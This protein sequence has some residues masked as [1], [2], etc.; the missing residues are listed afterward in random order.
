MIP[1]INK[2]GILIG[3]GGHNRVRGVGKNPKINKR[4]GMFIWDLRVHKIT[5]FLFEFLFVLT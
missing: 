2:R 3:S 5:Y 1:K 4:G